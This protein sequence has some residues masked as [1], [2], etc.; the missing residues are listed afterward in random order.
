AFL[1]Q[2][3][4]NN[5]SIV[6]VAETDNAVVGF[7]QMYPTFSTVGLKVAYILNDLFVSA[8]SRGQG[9]A[10]A[11]MEAC[12]AYCEDNN[13]RYVALETA[14]TNEQAQRLYEKMGMHVD[15]EMLHYVR[16]W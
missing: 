9:A 6:F 14:R 10:Q 12:F 1:T 8:E 3:L 2:R 16:Y 15:E 5:D 4:A 11:L 7:V 13:A